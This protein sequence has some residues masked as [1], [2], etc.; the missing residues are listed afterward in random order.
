MISK[1]KEVM[2]AAMKFAQARLSPPSYGQIGAEAALDT[3]RSYF[4]NVKT[5][6]ISRRDFLIEE[7]NKIDGVFCPK[8]SGA[9][10]CI[11]RLPI[12]DADKFCQWLLESFEYNKQTV[13][14]A[15]ATGFYSTPG[16]GKNEVRLAYVLKKED[17]SNAIIIRQYSSCFQKSNYQHV[18]CW[19]L[20]VS[21]IDNR[22]SYL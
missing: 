6:Y 4:E 22:C 1:N 3:P 12:D 21:L 9:F 15:P 11:A 19:I 16:A 8:P 13:M 20:F 10:Y 14:M 17:L 7:L 2:T 18:S 5:E